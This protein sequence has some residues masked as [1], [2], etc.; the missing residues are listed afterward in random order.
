MSRSLLFHCSWCPERAAKRGEQAQE[1]L[2]NILCLL[3]KYRRPTP[4]TALRSNNDPQS[5][6]QPSPVCS[7]WFLAVL[8]PVS[9][10]TP[11]HPLWIPSLPANPRPSPLHQVFSWLLLFFALP[12]TR[13]QHKCFMHCLSSGLCYPECPN[14][15][16]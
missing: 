4:C 15:M 9:L 11:P 5:L 12:F 14:Q 6:P 2:L 7:K 3:L 16:D 8:G 13:K 1:T 10:L